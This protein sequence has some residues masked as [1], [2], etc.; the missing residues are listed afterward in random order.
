MVEISDLTVGYRGVSVVE[1]VS[2]AFAPGEVLVLVGPNGCGK[3]T[4]IRSVL[5]LQEP[6]RGEVLFDGR[7]ASTLS[8][9]EI[10]QKAAFLP[11]SRNVPNITA[12]RMV[13][14]GRFPYLSYPRRYRKEDHAAA[15]KALEQ[16]GAGD[17]ADR[18]LPEL[19]G[20][21]RQKV[22]LAMALAQD[23]QT[24]FMDEPT[25]YLDVRHQLEVM[26]TA[27]QMAREGKAVVAVLHDLYLAL[28][29]AHRIGVVAQGRLLALEEPEA[30]YESGILDRVFG[31]KLGRVPTERGWQYYYDDGP[32]RVEAGGKR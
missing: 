24:I 8:A 19:S 17:L 15:Q 22:Y 20:G 28:R 9:R 7:P 14:H 30:V 18:Y 13:L 29:A 6:L 31:V 4:L 16:A 27:R 21:E 3:S 10:A 23:T 26:E 2:I 32:Q 5:G 25:T 1:D 11:Q 12:G